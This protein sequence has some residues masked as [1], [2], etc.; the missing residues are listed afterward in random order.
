VQQKPRGRPPTDPIKLQKYLA[1]GGV[2]RKPSI[3][4]P[5]AKTPTLETDADIIE[6]ISRRFDVMYD[7]TQGAVDGTVRAAMFSGAGGVGKS[8]MVRRVLEEA[9]AK[10]NLQYEFVSGK[11]TGVELYKKLYINREPGNVLVLDD[12]DAMWWD[13]ECVGL[14]KTALDSSVYRHIAWLTNSKVL[15]DDHVENECD[16]NG[17]C[18]FISNM[19]FDA[20]IASNRAPKLIPHMSALLTRCMYLNLCIHEPRQLILWIRHIVEKNDIL[21]KDGLEKQEQAE[22]LNWMQANMNKLRN[23]SIR[24]ALQLGMLRK[25]KP[26]EWK[27]IAEV[28]C[29]KNIY[30][31]AY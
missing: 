17:A 10:K 31:N 2:L 19:D 14:L 5:S 7:L 26:T 11:I 20:Y 13:E 30:A 24:T 29:F 9:K 1:A 18:L 8:F 23:L 12:A 15:K 16:Y 3:V 28:I 6:T 4:L 27:Q 22:I 25:T 21:I